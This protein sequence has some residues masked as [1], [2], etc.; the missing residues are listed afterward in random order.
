MEQDYLKRQIDQLGKVLGKILAEILRLKKQGNVS[1]VVLVSHQMFKSELDLDID[2][3]LNI[4]YSDFAER[5]VAEYDFN[6]N[7]LNKLADILLSLAEGN[8][9][10]REVIHSKCIQIYEYLDKTERTFSFDRQA[11]I[12]Q[13]RENL[14]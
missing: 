4:P 9:Y 13:I 2:E 11:K 1:D 8:A 3:I 5:L 7:T 14:L 10:K 6:N 12:E